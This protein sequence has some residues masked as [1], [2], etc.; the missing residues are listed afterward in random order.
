MEIS[1]GKNKMHFKPVKMVSDDQGSLYD[2]PDNNIGT[3]Q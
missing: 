2:N 1:T 3:F